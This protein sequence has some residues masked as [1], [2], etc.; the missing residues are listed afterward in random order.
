MGADLTRPG[1][2]SGYVFDSARVLRWREV[3]DGPTCQAWIECPRTVS[4]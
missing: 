4:T 3:P 1:C 2:N